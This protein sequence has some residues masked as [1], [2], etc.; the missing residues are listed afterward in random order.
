MKGIK[1]IF[2]KA[3]SLVTLAAV[4][5][6][7]VG[8]VASPAPIDPG[9]DPTQSANKPAAIKAVNLMAGIES[10]NT[11]S[12]AVPAAASSNKAADFAVRLFKACAEE[13]ENALVSPLSVLAALS[14]TANGAKGETLSQM[15]DVLGMSVDEL[16]EFY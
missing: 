3:L 4:L 5:F 12:P 7:A 6:C 1:R 10:K 8:C 16:N 14:M 9:A 2:K 13:G 11:V 15:E